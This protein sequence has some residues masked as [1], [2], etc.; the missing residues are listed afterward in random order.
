MFYDLET[1]FNKDYQNLAQAYSAV[2]FPVLRNE[3]ES[4]IM[5]P[6]N[7]KEYLARCQVF[8]G[9]NCVGDMVESMLK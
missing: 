5:T 2:V 7:I 1:I 8:T 9:N 6:E 3:F 4:M